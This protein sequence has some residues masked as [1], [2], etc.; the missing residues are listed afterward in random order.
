M[1]MSVCTCM[2][3]SMSVCMCVCVLW[4]LHDAF[5]VWR[6]A[7]SSRKLMSLCTLTGREGLSHGVRFSHEG[8]GGSRALTLPVNEGPR[9]CRRHPARV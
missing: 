2:C 1:R 4:L 9:P 5:P 8:E 6:P 3:V 7:T